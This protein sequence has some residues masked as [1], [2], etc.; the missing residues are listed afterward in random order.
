MSTYTADDLRAPIRHLTVLDLI[1]YATKTNAGTLSV[2]LD[3]A[4][5]AKDKGTR[6]LEAAAYHH[7]YNALAPRAGLW[8]S[9]KVLYRGPG[10]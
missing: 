9:A 8:A 3:E 4:L 2:C 1:S 7:D 10:G 6:H 5:G